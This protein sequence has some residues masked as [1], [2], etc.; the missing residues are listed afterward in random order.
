MNFSRNL[1]LAIFTQPIP[2]PFHLAEIFHPHRLHK[3]QRL[4]A[5]SPNRKIAQSLFFLFKTARG[6]GLLYHEPGLVFGLQVINFVLKQDIILNKPNKI[7]EDSI[8]EAHPPVHNLK[9]EYFHFMAFEGLRTFIA[10]SRTPERSFCVA[11]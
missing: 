3:K 2:A 4:R 7:F 10:H 9:L 8:L 6:G 1:T 5:R 11:Q